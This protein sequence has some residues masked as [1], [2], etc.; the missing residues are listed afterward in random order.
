[1]GF[2]RLSRFRARAATL[3]LLLLASACSSCIVT[4]VMVT[5]YYNASGGGDHDARVAEA[6][7]GPEGELALA[8]DEL[9]GVCRHEDYVLVLTA[10]ELDEAFAAPSSTTPALPVPHVRLP[11]AVLGRELAFARP[12][13]GSDACLPAAEWDPRVT[14]DQHRQRN[15]LPD[16]PAEAP[17]AIHW[18]HA[19]WA[20][21]QHN[22]FSLLVSR[23]TT[24]G[25][26]HALFVLDAFEPPKWTYVLVPLALTADLVLILALFG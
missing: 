7:R 10:R 8:L 15:V 3:A 1:M 22:G 16:S 20:G 25:F 17:L 26:E 9:E 2:H 11:R 14:D 23:K 21:E 18:T 19:Y 5:G 24:K 4:E 13:P 12:E 6:W